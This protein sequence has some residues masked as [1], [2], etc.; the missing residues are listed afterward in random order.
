[1]FKPVKQQ[2]HTDCQ[3]INVLLQNMA[4]QWYDSGEWY[5]ICHWSTCDKQFI[6][7]TMQQHTTISSRVMPR[8]KSGWRYVDCCS[9]AYTDPQT[10]TQILGVVCTNPQSGNLGV[11][12]CY[13]AAVIPPT[14]GGICHLRL[15]WH[16]ETAGWVPLP[17]EY[18]NIMPLGWFDDKYCRKCIHFFLSLLTMLT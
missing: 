12:C 8:S 15:L 6:S 10:G 4:Y 18:A 11:V 3:I 5:W 13:N 17:D 9:A 14:H 1:M 2:E 7:H 16:W